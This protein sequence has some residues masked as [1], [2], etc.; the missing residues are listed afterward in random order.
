LTGNARH[1]KN[2]YALKRHNTVR[3][4]IDL[5]DKLVDQAMAL[6]EWPGRKTKRALVEAALREYIQRSR[7]GKRLRIIHPDENAG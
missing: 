3:L 5:D 7:E 4:T 6:W 2:I 1:G